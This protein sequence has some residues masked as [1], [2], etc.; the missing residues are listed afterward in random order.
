MG[1][2]MRDPSRICSVSCFHSGIRSILAA[3]VG[4]DFNIAL[5]CYHRWCHAEIR[6]KVYEVSCDSHRTFGL[7]TTDLSF[8]TCFLFSESLQHI[9]EGG[10]FAEE[11]IS[12]I[13]TAQVSQ[14]QKEASFNHSSQRPLPLSDSDL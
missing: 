10:S 4:H 14:H 3:V 5:Y 2:A 8:F 7:P 6:I 1:F 9:A 13:R 12:T 11:V